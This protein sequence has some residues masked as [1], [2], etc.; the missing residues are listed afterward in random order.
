MKAIILAAGI[1]KR[2]KVYTDKPKCLIEL[3]GSSLIERYLKSFEEFGIKDVVIVAGYKIELIEKKIQAVSFTGNI[4]IIKN[5]DYSK[6]SILSVWSVK[7]ELKEDI[8]FM[9]GDVFFE[10]GILV[11]LLGSGYAN[12]LIIDTTSASTGEECIAGIKKGRVSTIQ[13]GLC[14]DF[15]MQG[16]WVGFLKMQ[17][18]AAVILREIVEDNVKKGNLGIGYEDILPELFS[19]VDFGFE[20][21][22]GLKWVE[23]DFPEDVKRAGNYLS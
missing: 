9:D 19:K 21:V 13:R 4:R 14:G 22:D 12:S 15:D 5:P 3:N 1:G 18:D 7:E 11:K 20:L 17:K 23:L 2:I 10:K 8:L 16:E 6:G